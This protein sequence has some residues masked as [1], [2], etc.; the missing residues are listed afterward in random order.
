MRN[1]LHRIRDAGFTN[2]LIVVVIV[3]VFLIV[4]RVDVGHVV[5]IG[6]E[7]VMKLIELFQ[8]LIIEPIQKFGA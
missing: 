7:I 8:V 5:Q 4:M 1:P 3:I 2:T 6:K